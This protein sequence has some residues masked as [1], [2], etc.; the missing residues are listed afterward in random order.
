MCAAC[1]TVSEQAEYFGAQLRINSL[2]STVLMAEQHSM[3]LFSL[4]RL[5]LNQKIV[6]SITG[7]EQA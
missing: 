6:L 1:V 4:V 5:V 3:V 7:N 2:F